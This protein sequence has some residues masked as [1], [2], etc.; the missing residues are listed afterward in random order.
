MV[1]MRLNWDGG[2][3]YVDVTP[4]MGFFCS[5]FACCVFF[6]C[7]GVEGGGG[8][9][10]YSTL[11]VGLLRSKIEDDTIGRPSYLIYYCHISHYLGKMQVLFS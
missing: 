7:G 6:W 3:N 11:L 9:E 10:Y 1:E 8:V 4:N 5:L 2:S